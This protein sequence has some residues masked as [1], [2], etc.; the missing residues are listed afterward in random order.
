MDALYATIPILLVLITMTVFRK[1]S[2]LAGLVGWLSGLVMAVLA[3]GLNWQV[4]WV[5]QGK[6][7]LLSLNVLLILWPALLLYTLV[8]QVGGIRAIAKGLQ[9]LVPDKG[10]LAIMEAWLLTAII[11]SLAGFGMPIA[12]VSPLLMTLGV[13][14]VLAVAVAAIGHTW[15]VS[16]GGM[17]L[18]VRTL[19]GVTN[20]PLEAM[21]PASAMLLGVTAILSGLAV[22][23]LLNEKRHW[24][25]VLLVGLIIAAVQYLAGL[26]GLISVCAFLSALTGVV[27]GVLLGPKPAGWKPGREGS[28]ALRAGLFGY[29]TLILL[30]IVVSVIKPLNEFLGEFSWT[31]QFPEVITN[32][33]MVTAAGHG[34]ELRYFLHAGTLLLISSGLSLFVFRAIPTLDKVNLKAALKTTLK[35]ATPA[36]LG[37]LFMIGLSTVMDHTGMTTAMAKNLSGL[38]GSVYPLLTPMVG[39]VG[40]FAT[41]SN[42]NS[43][44]LFGVLQ[45]E[46]AG[47]IGASPIILLAGQTTGGALGSMIAPA[48]LAVG[49]STSNLKGREGEVMRITLPV[50]I[51]MA[52]IVGIITWIIA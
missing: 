45:K 7:L 16:L 4:F 39:V 38:F 12:I 36:S 28:P 44:V 5:S 43:N 41:G 20:I 40:S 50:G 31:L 26:L 6:G 24:K 2:A 21:F 51:V 49:T 33:G 23:F 47:F 29:G 19:S 9:D 32:T 14:P 48:K 15:T 11:E 27:C 10:W 30:I 13:P 42:T 17:A 46:I 18:P 25:R 34:Y 22:M 1:G 52:L 3:F 35:G 8:D 37:T